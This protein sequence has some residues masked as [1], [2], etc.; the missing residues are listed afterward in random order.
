M[1]EPIWKRAGGNLALALMLPVTNG[2]FHVFVFCSFFGC[3]LVQI[4]VVSFKTQ[5]LTQT[6]CNLVCHNIY[7]GKSS[8][9]HLSQRSVIKAHLSR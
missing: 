8:L 3:V 4:L 1:A 5:S 6:V 9:C 7:V 2:C